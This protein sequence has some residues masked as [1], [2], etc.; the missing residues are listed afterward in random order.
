MEGLQ[1]VIQRIPSKAMSI[2][3]LA[4]ANETFRSLCADFA[5]AQAALSR[6]NE[7][8]SR[9]TEQRRHEYAS[10]VEELFTEINDAINEH[11][12]RPGPNRTG[13]LNRP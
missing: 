13:Q 6:L 1:T 3:R 10:L 12:L 2:Q 4:L 8:A 11:E 7:S 9:E 5:E